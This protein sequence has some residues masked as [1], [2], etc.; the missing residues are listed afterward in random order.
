[1]F[2]STLNTRYGGGDGVSL[3]QQVLILE[4]GI[5]PRSW[6]S[7]YHGTCFYIGGVVA[8]GFDWQSPIAIGLFFGGVAGGLIMRHLTIRAFRTYAS[9]VR[10]FEEKYLCNK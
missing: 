10:N 4:Q 9:F 6:N 3:T 2:A 8:A 7:L 5:V 1:M